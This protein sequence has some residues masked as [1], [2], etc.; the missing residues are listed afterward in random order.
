MAL[1]LITPKGNTLL[2]VAL[3]YW[4][5]LD[6]ERGFIL[7]DIPLIDKKARLFEIMRQG[8]YGKGSFI[9]GA[10]MRD[11]APYALAWAASENNRRLGGVHFSFKRGLDLNEAHSLC[12]DFLDKARK[13]FDC[14]T[15][16]AP[17]KF[18]GARLFAKRLG[19]KSAAILPDLCWLAEHGKF[20][21][22]DLL[23]L[24]FGKDWEPD[25]PP[26]LPWIDCY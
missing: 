14:L 19:F 16:I 12:R 24:E 4:D 26:Y 22:G 11:N 18:I 20:C 3:N 23:K 25:K 1:K 8:A 7:W 13:L 5:S 6:Q 17:V 9:A 10:I 15:A 21:A 2:Y